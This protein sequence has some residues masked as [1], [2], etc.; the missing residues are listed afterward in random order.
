MKLNRLL[1]SSLVAV[2]LSASL[3]AGTHGTHWGY[4]GH[5]SNWGELSPEFAMCK[6]GVN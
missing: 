4:T 6:D 5:E 3:L 1:K 2:A